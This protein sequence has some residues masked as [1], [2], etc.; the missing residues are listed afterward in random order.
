[1]TFLRRSKSYF[2]TE[3]NIVKN[4]EYKFKIEY[5]ICQLFLG[6]DNMK[7]IKLALRSILHFRMY[8]G[9]NILGMALSLACV[10]VIFRYVYGELTVDQFNE[11]IDRIYV[12]MLERGTNVGE[13]HFSGISERYGIDMFKHS[14]VENFSHFMW[15]E[16][17]EIDVDNQKYN[18]NILLADSN[19]LKITDY[20]VISGVHKTDNLH[21]ALVSESFAKRIFGNQDPIGKSFRHSS[22]EILTISGILG[23]TPTKSSLNFDI[24]ASYQLSEYLSSWPSNMTFVLLHPNV[25]YTTINKQYEDFFEEPFWK[26]QIRYQLF[27]M[28]KLYLDKSVAGSAFLRGNYSYIIVLM[29]VGI[30]ILLVG[31][32]NYINIYTVVILRRGRELGIKKV[33]G[34]DGHNILIQLLTENLLITG[35]TL[36]A[37]L[38][39]SY[40]ASPLITNVLQLGQISNI[41]FDIFLSFAL[42]LSLPLITTVFPFFRYH[43]STSV[44][45]LRNFDKI[46]GGSLRR[47]FLTFQYVI[48]IVMIIVSL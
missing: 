32:I 23:E 38:I 20:Y 46:Q 17:D 37:A 4:G 41:R 9:I 10:I 2:P 6:R 30:L 12:T 27:P 3:V 13:R 40:A 11:K 36:I 15:F 1:M 24:V 19:F 22:N 33:F 39:F 14:G 28:S 34:A 31:I 44:N 48:T 25:D 29:A 7:T 21:G 42:L 43:Y 8:S 5:I 16:N 35:L 18:A 47:F 45:S 26:N